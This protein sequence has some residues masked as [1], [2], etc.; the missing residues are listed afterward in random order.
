MAMAFFLAMLEAFPLRSGD[1]ATP[2]KLQREVDSAM[3]KLPGAFV[4]VDVTSRTV[5]AAH[6][7]DRASLRL[8]AP[9]STLKPFLLMAL[10][11]TS[12][13]DPKQQ[14]ICHKPLKIGSAQ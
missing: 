6:G 14:F 13:L 4:V 1:S 7:M 10:L 8:E 11:E 5:L 2:S 9:G 12:R 3:G